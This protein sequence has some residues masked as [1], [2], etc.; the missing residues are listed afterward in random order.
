MGICRAADHGGGNLKNAT[1]TKS[2]P[3]SAKAGKQ[4]QNTEL[5]RLRGHNFNFII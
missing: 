2:K 1:N 3:I 4:L 5:K